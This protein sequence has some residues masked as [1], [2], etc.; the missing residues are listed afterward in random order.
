GLGP[1][2]RL[3]GWPG[4]SRYATRAGQPTRIARCSGIVG[5]CRSR[6]GWVVVPWWNPL[7]AGFS[8]GVFM[9]EQVLVGAPAEPARRRLFAQVRRDGLHGAVADAFADNKEPPSSAAL[10]V[11]HQELTVHTLPSYRSGAVTVIPLRWYTTSDFDDRFPDVDANLELEQAEP[12]T[13]RLGLTGIYRSPTG[14]PATTRQHDETRATIRHFLTRLADIL[15][16]GARDDRQQGTTTNQHTQ[17]D[18]LH[19]A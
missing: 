5:G 7:E 3:P 16:P 6:Q 12:G 18:Q 1:V 19:C 17:S 2:N 8:G 4:H 15:A 9:S 11:P 14:Q 13:S 10:P